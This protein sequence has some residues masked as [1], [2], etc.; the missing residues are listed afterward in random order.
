MYQQVQKISVLTNTS[1]FDCGD[2]DL[3]DFLKTDA[4][5]DSNNWISSTFVLECDA[6]VIGFFTIAWDTIQSGKI[7]ESDQ[8]ENYP[9]AK[10]SAIKL[11]R[12]GVDKAWQRKGV[13]TEL[14]ISFYKIAKLS[15]HYGGGRY[16]TVDAKKTAVEFYRKFSFHA[17]NSKRNDET[18]PMYLDFYSFVNNAVNNR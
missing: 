3:N 14:M 8:V 7:N 12:L 13:G 11:A 18:V 10:Y 5:R 17:V 15:T 1:G 9:Y 2:D 16:I 6:K 4:L